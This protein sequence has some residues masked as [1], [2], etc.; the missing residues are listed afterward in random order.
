MS[1]VL[2]IEPNY[3]AKFPPLGLLRIASYHKECGD[4]VAFSRGC[5]PELRELKWRK[6]YVSSLFTYELPRTVRTIKY[7]RPSVDS[8]DDIIVGGVGATLMPDYIRQNVS[9]RIIT[10]PLTQPKMLGSESRPI[11]KYLPDYSIIA[12]DGRAYQPPDSYFCRV[13]TGCIRRC[14]FCAVPV[15]EPRFSYLQPLRKQVQEV[16]E[17]FG[18]R[19]NLVLLDNNILACENIEKIVGDIKASGFEHGALRNGRKRKV[20]FNQGIDARLITEDV[21]RLLS[22]VALSPV[23]LAFDYSGVQ[24]S[25]VAAV[26][27]MASFGFATFTTYIMFNYEDDPCDF[28]RR[29]TL[30]AELSKELNI[31][32]SGFPMKYTPIHEVTRRYVS[33]RWKWRYLRG[34][35]CILLATHG[36]VSPHLEFVRGAFGSS[37]EEF[38]EILSMPDRYIIQRKKY[39]GDGA[40]DWR[41]SFRRLSASSRDEFLD[42]LSVINVS[43]D[44]EEA[45]SQHKRYSRLLEHYYPGGKPVPC[46]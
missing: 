16:T 41:K 5:N 39:E 35:Q 15:L 21:A 7:Y 4:R 30:N 17:R 2:L 20:D 1:N 33:P 42:A 22:S 29:M 27:L 19:Q 45:I 37:E 11:A 6:I 12:D 44:K 32:V 18:E 43:R 3:R 23:R 28:Y 34:M 38:L 31:R 8:N 9:C 10:G 25:Y 46:T 36:L 26:R 40:A 14:G 24:K 13:T